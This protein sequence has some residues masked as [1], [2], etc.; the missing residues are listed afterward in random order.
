MS[1]VEESKRLA[2]YAAVDKHV[3]PHHKVPQYDPCRRLSGYTHPH[4]D[5]RDRFGY[6]HIPQ[7]LPLIQM[8]S[9]LGS[10]VPYVVDRIVQQGA[11]LN[12][13]RVFVPTGF[14]SKELIIHADLNLGDVDQFLS[15]DVTID[16]ADESVA[17][18][19]PYIRLTH[20]ALPV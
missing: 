19:P 15:I 7:Y 10:T 18:I 4:R 9:S 16:G 2:A 12:K 17:S 6:V 3:L 13:E 20:Y 14:Q 11:G 1:I 5:H 8:S